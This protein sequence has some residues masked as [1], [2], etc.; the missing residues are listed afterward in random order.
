MNTEQ[1]RDLARR[2]AVHAALAD[3]TRLLITDALDG[4]DVSPSEL[5]TL[6]GMPSNLLAHPRN[7]LEQPGLI[8]RHRSEGDR[9]RNYLRL[10]PAPLDS[11]TRPTAQA[12]RRGAVVWCAN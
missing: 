5:A 2:A 11:L 12:A 4:C 1:S 7:V 9:R 3:P 6:L 8:S 10:M